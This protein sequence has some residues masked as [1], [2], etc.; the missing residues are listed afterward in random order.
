MNIFGNQFNSFNLHSYKKHGHPEPPLNK[1]NYIILLKNGQLVANVYYSEKSK[2][3]ISEDGTEYTE[4][5]S[6]YSDMG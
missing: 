1:H 3:F 4:E 6:Y 5:V 2:S